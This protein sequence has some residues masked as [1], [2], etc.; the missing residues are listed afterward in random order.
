MALYKKGQSGNPAGRPKGI[1]DSRMHYRKLLEPHIPAVLNKLIEL[2]TAGDATAMRM[3]LE[4]VIP[5]VNSDTVNLSPIDKSKSAMEQLTALSEE[6]D[7]KVRSGEFSVETGTALYTMLDNRRKLL[8]TTEL[9][10][11][12]KSLEKTNDSKIDNNNSNP[13]LK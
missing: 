3:F 7:E 1:Q 11:R 9:E 12:I 13:E 10:Q 6:I 8:D 5:R 4:R 2:A